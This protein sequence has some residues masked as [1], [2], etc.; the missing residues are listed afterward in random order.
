MRPLQVTAIQEWIKLGGRILFLVGS[1]GKTVLA[2]GQPFAEFAPGEFQ[3]VV[4]LRRNA[5]LEHFVSAK[6]RLDMAQRGAAK[7]LAATSLG[8]VRG[9]V[10]V[11]EGTGFAG[12]VPLVIRS[13]YGLGYVLFA[14]FDLDQPPLSTW[15]NDPS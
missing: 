15:E 4:S 7:P 10:E 13:W 6:S 3:A 12:E 2:E 5:G 1:Q 8:K 9:R 14:A 11:Y